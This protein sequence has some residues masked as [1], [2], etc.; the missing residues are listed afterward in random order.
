MTCIA[1]LESDYRN[2]VN[3]FSISHEKGMSIRHSFR[4]FHATNDA[5]NFHP[6]PLSHCSGSVPFELRRVAQSLLSGN[7]MLDGE[8]VTPFNIIVLTRSDIAST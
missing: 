4:G 1:T 5:V 3:A 7:N 2:L 8:T 6:T